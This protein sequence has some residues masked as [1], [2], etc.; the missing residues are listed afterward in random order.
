MHQSK[1]KICALLCLEERSG[2]LEALVERACLLQKQGADLIELGSIKAQY[3]RQRLLPAL[4]ALKAALSIPIW[5]DVMCEEVA[6]EALSLGA[7]CICDRSGF[8]DVSMRKMAGKS[9][10]QVCVV[11]CPEHSTFHE[12]GIVAEVIDWLDKQTRLLLH[13]GVEFDRI[14]IDLGIGEG[15]TEQEN[16]ELLRHIQP[17]R[18]L[19]FRISVGIDYKSLICKDVN[20]SLPA[21]IALNSFLML[22]HVDIIRV[23]DVQAHRDAFNHLYQLVI[24]N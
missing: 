8:R 10:A 3:E 11:H 15:K 4:K 21:L 23:H 24:S 6:R 22:S 18:Q 2:D 13:D 19:G 20:R 12:K 14:V 5:I 7:D 1:T 17:F 16:F 9:G